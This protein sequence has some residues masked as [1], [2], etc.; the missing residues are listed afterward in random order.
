MLELNELFEIAA[1]VAERVQAGSVLDG[2]MAHGEATLVVDPR[3]IVPIIRALRDEPA[4]ALDM[5]SDVTAV[6][7]LELGRAA[8]F[9]VVYHLV[10]LTHGHR[11]RLR[12]PLA[13]QNGEYAIDS[14]CGLWRGADFMERETFDMFGIKFIDHPDLRRI[15]MPE[16]WDG[17]PLR[18]DFP[19]GGAKSFYTRQDTEEYAGEPGDLIP[20]IRV[21]E[22][23]V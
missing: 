4:L 5:L 15:L 1:A 17:H 14:I 6:D 21:Q 20:R 2:I 7:Y 22:G 9:D 16:D 8:R 13:E 3:F 10:S 19:L 11:L 23:E 12:A 18:K